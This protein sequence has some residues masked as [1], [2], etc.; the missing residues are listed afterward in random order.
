M[1]IKIFPIGWQVQ[2]FQITETGAV[3]NVQSPE[4]I[5]YYTFEVYLCN[6]EY[7]FKIGY[8]FCREGN[9]IYS[10]DRGFHS[11]QSQIESI[12]NATTIPLTPPSDLTIVRSPLLLS[13]LMSPPATGQQQ[14]NHDQLALLRSQGCLSTP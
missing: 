8:V 12:V 4:Y 2:D 14:S 6:R 10:I 5:E 3:R 11:L 13:H 9:A 1:D 7:S